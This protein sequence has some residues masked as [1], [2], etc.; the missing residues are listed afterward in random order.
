MPTLTNAAVRNNNAADLMRRGI[1]LHDATRL[2]AIAR[3]LHH[4]AER[5]CNEEMSDAQQARLD[6][7]E[8]RMLSEAAMIAQSA[9]LLL[10]HQ[11]DPRGWPLYL[12]AQADLDAYNARFSADR[13]YRIDAVY[14]SIGV[15]VCPY[16]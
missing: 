7:R 9:G 6:K 4:A 2:Q 5:E 16:R 13:T 11:S 3:S 8:Q 14:N 12:W 15:A 10:Y 1:A